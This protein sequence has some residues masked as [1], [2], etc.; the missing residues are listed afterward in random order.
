MANLAR[1]NPFAELTRFD[2]FRDFD[3]MFRFPQAFVRNVPEEPQIR[4]DVSED[5]RAFVVK[6]EIP[7]VRK[8]DIKV[9]IDGNRVSI[10]AELKKEKEEKKG[11]TVIRSERYYGRQFRGFTLHQ[12]VDASKAE[13]SYENGVLALTLPKKEPA[14]VKEIAVR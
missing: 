5:D 10:T 13:A 12:D 4:M 3:D 11:E 8:D 9:S 14:S 1:F 6:A 7:G 2:P